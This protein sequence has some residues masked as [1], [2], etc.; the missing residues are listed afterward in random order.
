MLNK[1]INLVVY[2]EEKWSTSELY[3]LCF[4]VIFLVESILKNSWT[5]LFVFGV[6]FIIEIFILMY[7][8]K[9]ELTTFT[10]EHG[11]DNCKSINS[12]IDKDET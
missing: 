12:E 1:I 10:N 11:C 6:L 7:R 5:L 9:K 3:I 8:L 2:G 4:A